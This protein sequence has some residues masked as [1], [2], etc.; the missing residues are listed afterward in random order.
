MRMPYLHKNLYIHKIIY[1]QKCEILDAKNV[2]LFLDI[3]N[4]TTYCLKP[5]YVL[6]SA[7]KAVWNVIKTYELFVKNYKI[8]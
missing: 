3:L 7:L 5:F 8:T 2:I 4:S 1:S 6:Q